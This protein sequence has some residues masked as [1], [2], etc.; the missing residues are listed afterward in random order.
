M[1]IPIPM[2]IRHR[3]EGGAQPIA[4]YI[5]IGINVFVY[6]FFSRESMWVGPGTMPWTILTPPINAS[7][8][9]GSPAVKRTSCWIA[10][11]HSSNS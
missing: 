8:C 2:Q 7:D 11:R 6:I 9:S 3:N 10:T 4:N 1:L 5:L